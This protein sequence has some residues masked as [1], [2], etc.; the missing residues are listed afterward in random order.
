MIDTRKL[1]YELMAVV[2]E[3][4]SGKTFDETCLRTVK[5]VMTELLKPSENH[6]AF[7]K[8]VAEIESNPVEKAKLDAARAE[9]SKSVAKRLAV[10]VRVRE[11][12]HR[13]PEWDY[14]QIDK[15]MP[16]F[17]SCKCDLKPRTPK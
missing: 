8:L 4:E 3:I 14:L 12:A 13:C 2:T 7:D 1:G 16:E 5:F 6:D 17:E 15:S 9:V 10:Q 11:G